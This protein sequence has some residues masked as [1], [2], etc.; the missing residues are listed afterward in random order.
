MISK[1]NAVKGIFMVLEGIGVVIIH[2]VGKIDG[3]YESLWLMAVVLIFNNITEKIK[4]ASYTISLQFCFGNFTSML[5]MRSWKV[6]LP[7]L[8]L[9]VRLLC[10][11]ANLYNFGIEIVAIFLKLQCH[12]GLIFKVKIFKHIDVSYLL[13]SIVSTIYSIFYYSS[14]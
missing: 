8:M 4:T 3:E 9:L 2:L 7:L 1:E 6:K 5:S 11:D 13:I 12:H 14:L 10:L